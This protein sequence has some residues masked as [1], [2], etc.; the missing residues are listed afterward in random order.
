MQ[1]KLAADLG[2]SIAILNPA[3]QT[4][5]KWWVMDELYVYAAGATADFSGIK[6]TW[7]VKMSVGD[8]EAA[9]KAAQTP[10]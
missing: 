4:A 1:K 3:K 5:Q 9:G 10:Y 6:A 7:V 8:L 2:G